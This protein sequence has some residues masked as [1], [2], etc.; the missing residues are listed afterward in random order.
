MNDLSIYIIEKLH[1][2]KNTKVQYVRP[3]GDRVYSESYKFLKKYLPDI[4]EW[5]YYQE[6][7]DDDPNNSY[8]KYHFVY[9]MPDLYNKRIE[10]EH[11]ITSIE[12]DG[13]RIFNGVI[14][15]WKDKQ[16]VV[17]YL[18]KKIVKDLY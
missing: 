15:L 7:I 16:C 5:K 10:M 1:L 3:L 9:S 2:D 14:G 8:I 4:D 11:Q 12:I 6:I 17:F 13:D 18:N